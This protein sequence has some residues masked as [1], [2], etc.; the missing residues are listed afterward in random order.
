MITTCS[1]FSQSESIGGE[2][3]LSIFPGDLPRPA[4]RE[5]RRSGNAHLGCREG[6]A[7]ACVRRCGRPLGTGPGATGKARIHSYLRTLLSW[8]VVWKRGSST[9]YTCSDTSVETCREAIPANM[10]PRTG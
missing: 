2:A 4:W 3:S 9:A 6:S 7:I 10:R 8:L 5:H 1:E